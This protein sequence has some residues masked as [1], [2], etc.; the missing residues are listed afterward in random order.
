MDLKIKLVF[1][2]DMTAFLSFFQRQNFRKISYL[3]IK[4][5]PNDLLEDRWLGTFV[6][7][8]SLPFQLQEERLR[9]G[10]FYLDLIYSMQ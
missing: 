10:Y 3:I 4:L 5:V 8:P 7:Q 6:N 1:S 2:A 9:K